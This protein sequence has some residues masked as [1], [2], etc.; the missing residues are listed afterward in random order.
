MRQAKGTADRQDDVS[1]Q[2][3]VVV[4]P[5]EIGKILAVD[6][7]HRQIGLG[8]G[9]NDLRRELPFV[10][11][12]DF[13]VR[14]AVHDVVVRHDVPGGI[15]DDA[16]SSGHLRAIGASSGWSHVRL[17][18]ISGRPKGTR[19]AGT[20]EWA[21]R[22]SPEGPWAGTPGR[23]FMIA[24]ARIAR[25]AHPLSLRDLNVDDGRSDRLY[26]ARKPF[27]QLRRNAGSVRQRRRRR[28][29]CT[30]SRQERSEQTTTAHY[31]KLCL[32]G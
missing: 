7:D 26:D 32:H 14:S 13:N 1:H 17:I 30:G 22:R 3:L 19:S 4:A 10:V 11:K 23:T 31:A 21:G 25:T 27:N 12:K 2:E 9:A 8:I 24:A 5:F 20:P 6:L 15:Y 28:G 16:R 29:K 18:L